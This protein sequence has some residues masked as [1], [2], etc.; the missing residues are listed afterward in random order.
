MQVHTCLYRLVKILFFPFGGLGSYIR[1]QVQL[2]IINKISC[3]YIAKDKHYTEI[4]YDENCE[5]IKNSAFLNT[6]YVLVSD[7]W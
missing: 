6:A 2:F 1:V 4:G 7:L 5:G 3:S